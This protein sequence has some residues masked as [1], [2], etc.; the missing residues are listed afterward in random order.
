MMKL[1]RHELS[2]HAHRAELFL[3]L[4]GREFELI[5]ID[6]GAGEHKSEWFLKLNP[7]GQVPVL[8]DGE[9]VVG[10]STAIL[11]YL[12]KSYGAEWLPAD[13]VQAAQVQRWLSAASGEVASGPA[14]ARL[15]TVFGAGFDHE[16]VK[17]KAHRF[18]RVLNQHLTG[19]EFLVGARSTI[20][21]VAIYSYVAHAP[22]G[23][24]VLDDYPAVQS[25]IARIESLPGFVPMKKTVVETV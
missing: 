18:L 12:A 8:I 3:S 4:L 14:A 15:V 20:A 24:V 2:G 1:Y 7:F 9:K 25:W 22:E 11:V 21:D 19:R 16:V 10:D 5:D 23:G 13:A 17:A 6:L